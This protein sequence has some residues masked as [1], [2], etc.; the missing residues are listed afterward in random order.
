MST[1]KKWLSWLVVIVVLVALYAY[2]HH[3]DMDGAAEPGIEEPDKSSL[4]PDQTDPP[5]AG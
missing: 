2:T 3:P 5:A 4:L 1:W